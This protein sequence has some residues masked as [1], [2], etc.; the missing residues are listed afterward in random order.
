MSPEITRVCH[1]FQQITPGCLNSANLW[2]FVQTAD[3]R[4]AFAGL[5]MPKRYLIG[6]LLAVCAICSAAN[7]L[8][9][10]QDLLLHKIQASLQSVG[11]RE[12]IKKYFDCSNGPGYALVASGDPSAVRLG[13]DLASSSDACSA[14]VLGSSL[15]DAMRNNPEA[16]LPYVNSSPFFQDYHICTPAMIETPYDD[17]MASLKRQER[18]L[19]SVHNPA[20]IKQRNMCLNYIKRCIDRLKANEA[21]IRTEDAENRAL[22]LKRRQK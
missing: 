20:V 19:K 10:E 9:P 8:T 3:S 18:A 22:A 17:T 7:A 13:I 2:Y 11:G 16:V 15:A 6:T 21:S 4:T 1:T 12:T 5:K 14:E